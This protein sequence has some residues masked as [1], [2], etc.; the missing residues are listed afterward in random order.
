MSQ[1]NRPSC[2]RTNLGN[3]RWIFESW[4]DN[5]HLSMKC[6]WLDIEPLNC[7]KDG[8]CE[9]WH[10]KGYRVHSQIF[11]QGLR[12]GPE[13]GFYPV[14]TISYV[15]NWVSDRKDGFE[16]HFNSNGDILYRVVWTDGNKDGLE[17]KWDDNGILV[18]R[19][20]WRQGI[21]EER[22]EGPSSPRNIQNIG[23]SIM[24][25]LQEML[26]T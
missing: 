11:R 8:V 25:G 17:E 6:A 18:Y 16:Q 15:C 26:V 22:E 3:N 14:G 9:C 7:V 23:K 20:Y 10:E 2:R 5:G 12:D 1:I 13:A 19:C 24:T 4:Y 21:L